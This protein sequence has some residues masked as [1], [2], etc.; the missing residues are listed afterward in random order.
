MQTTLG[1]WT[2]MNIEVITKRG[3]Q[4]EY[5]TL[6]YQVIN[7][8]TTRPIAAILSDIGE[9]RILN[10]VLNEEYSRLNEIGY[11]LLRES[12][13]DRRNYDYI[14]AWLYLDKNRR[15]LAATANKIFKLYAL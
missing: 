6:P 4:V 3:D 2:E 14:N 12:I 5:F 10:I 13:S 11:R 8:I 1:V 15:N 9:F 7:L